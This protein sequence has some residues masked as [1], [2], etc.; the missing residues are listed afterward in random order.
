VSAQYL[1]RFCKETVTS[2]RDN[3]A[4]EAYNAR[5]ANDLLSVWL[6]SGILKVHQI[7][8]GTRFLEG[9]VAYESGD[10]PQLLSDLRAALKRWHRPTLGD[11]A[12]VDGLTAVQRRLV[13]NPR[14][15]RSNALRQTVQAAL[16][17]LRKRERTEQADLL[18]RRFLRNESVA[19]LTETYNLSERSI[20]HRLHEAC[21]AL[22]HAL[23]AL[24][25]TDEEAASDSVLATRP[26]S[27]SLRSRH[28][29]P[30]TS[31]NLFGMDELLAQLLHHL[32][33]YEGHWVISLDG[34][35]G[36]GKTA[37][38]REAASRMAET[39]R[40]AD[41]AWVT[42]RQVSYTS[43]SQQRTDLPALTCGQV[44]D[45]IA[46]QLGGFE[47]VDLPLP[48][49]RER[50]RD[51]LSSCPC[52]VVL[53]HLET[54]LDCGMLPDWL[55]D[56]A[57]PSKFLLTS[58]H[59]LDAEVGQSVLSLDQ[60]SEPD[61]LA[62]IRHEAHLR[63][64]REVVKANDNVLRRILAVTGGN[65]LAIKLVVGQL[66]SLPLDHILAALA[67]A[68]PDTDP[69]YEYLY[70]VSWDLVSAP[71]QHLLCSLTQL[72]ASGGT[73][74][75]LSAAS[76]LTGND[77][78]SA[79]EQL[80]IHSLLQATGFEEKIYSMHALTHHFALNKAAQNPA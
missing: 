24:E 15:T 51:L 7:S 18:E 65:P 3:P 34:M 67:T 43:G 61:C 38:A 80:T 60:L 44:L 20:Y 21:V 14:L 57:D 37:L 59:L 46:S 45:T 42:V 47:L 78:A 4:S 64:L 22:A 27:S 63:G 62:L 31:T 72:P 12:L 41:I 35:A 1:Q 33:D 50:V 68:Q 76:G 75:D 49:K 40:F 26:L 53:D 56:M 58:R 66:V 16:A 6:G 48:A 5:C 13:V 71:A 9:R 28:L 8:R 25:H 79:I 29:P 17:S 73:W 55:W 11:A 54:V 69:F 2:H 36:L 74:E 52:L 70:R 77:L 39:D 19:R 23:W 30:Q 10:D 32:D